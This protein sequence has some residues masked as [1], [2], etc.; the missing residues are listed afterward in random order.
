VLR[1]TILAAFVV[2]AAL[3]LYS[4]YEDNRLVEAEARRVACVGRAGTC[5]PRLARL[6]RTP[7]RQTFAFRIGT[8][9]LAVTCRHSLWLVG[10]Y[11]CEAVPT[12]R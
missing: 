5:A 10:A 11:G 8:T 7:L 1:L 9:D 3:A 2:V 6:E 12:P 4:F